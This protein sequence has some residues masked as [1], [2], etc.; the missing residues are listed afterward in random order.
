MD[1]TKSIIAA[2]MLLHNKGIMTN[3]DMLE[4]HMYAGIDDDVCTGNVSRH[5][6]AVLQVWL[7]L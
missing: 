6:N 7:K 2:A 1:M 3:L 5:E 4:A